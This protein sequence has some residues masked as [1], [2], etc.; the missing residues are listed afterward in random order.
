MRER[1]K[2]EI[3]YY[4]KIEKQYGY[5]KFSG[6]FLESAK[7]M[8]ESKLFITVDTCWAWISS[9]YSK[10]TIGLYSYGYYNGSSTAKNW[11]PI[12]PNLTFLEK[13]NLNNIEVEI[14]LNEVRNKLSI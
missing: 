1:R 4:K 10:E 12:N 3:M 5:E 7:I 8:L 13:Y 9:G 2:N 14:I 6:S 11:C